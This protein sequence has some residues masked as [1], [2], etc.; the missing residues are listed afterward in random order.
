M[1]AD[2]LAFM[3]KHSITSPTLIGHSMGAKTVMTLALAHPELVSALIPVDNAPID[4]ALKSDFHNYVRGMR[5]ISRAHIKKKNE[6]DKILEP[7]AKELG[8]RQFLLT[9]LVY[10]EDGDGL[11]WRIPLETLAGQ[12][13]KMG[14]FP[15]RN[16]EESQY[17]GPTLIVRGTKSPYVSDEALPVIGR[18]FPRFELADIDSGHWVTSEAPEPFRKGK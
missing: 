3:N 17:K 5:E 15:F 9:N 16:P 14:D 7:Y 1:A 11:E 10:R 13:D 6:A 12:L 4:A 8:V 18:F 2:V